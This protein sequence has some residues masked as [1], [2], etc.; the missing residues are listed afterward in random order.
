MV[1]TTPVVVP[2]NPPIEQIFQDPN[3]APVPFQCPWY[4]PWKMN[5]KYVVDMCEGLPLGL[6]PKR[7][8]TAEDVVKAPGS[9]NSEIVRYKNYVETFD[10]PPEQQVGFYPKTMMRKII[11]GVIQ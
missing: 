6:K 11:E 4:E 7:A 2:T 1:T 8:L 10:I 3:H 5:S 9:Y